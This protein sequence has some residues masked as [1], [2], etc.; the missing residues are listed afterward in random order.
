ML[1]RHRRV[2]E[3]MAHRLLSLCGAVILATFL[4]ASAIAATIGQSG[5]A[6]S[7]GFQAAGPSSDFVAGALVSTSKTNSHVV[8]LADDQSA[9][10]IIGV[11]GSGPLIQLT[12]GGDNI[13]VI[14]NGTASLLVSDLNGP[15]HSGDKITSSPIEGVGMLAS[16]S[17]QVVGTSLANLNLSR[18]ATRTITDGSY[19]HHTVHIGI[20]PTKVN[21]AY[22]QSLASSVLPPFLESLASAIAGKPVSAIRILLSAIILIVSLASIFALLYTATR[23]GLTSIGR[24]PLAANAVTR[25]LRSIGLITVLILAGGLA[26]VYFVLTL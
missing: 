25:N 18:S 15:I 22:Y 2:K 10:R 17:T 4:P 19:Q 11:V 21:V 5:M 9:S 23:S 6:F 24:N 3:H 13:Q 20:V 7:Q 1:L 14:I 12:Q 16:T 8:E 26:A